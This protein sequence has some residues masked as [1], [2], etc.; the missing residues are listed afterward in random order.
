MTE[1]RNASHYEARCAQLEAELAKERAA[2]EAAE[3]EAAENKAGW[4]RVNHKRG[5]HIDRS[6]QDYLRRKARTEAAEQRAEQALA[7][8]KKHGLGRVSP[9]GTAKCWEC[10]HEFTVESNFGHAADC[11]L[12]ALLGK[13]G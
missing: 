12:A 9:M 4:E 7:L 6:W 5:L 1:S 10:M 11:K 2:R 13:E 3:K 8:A